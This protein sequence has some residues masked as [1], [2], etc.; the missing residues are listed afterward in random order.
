[1]QSV[2]CSQSI[3][4]TAEPLTAAAG[5]YKFTCRMLWH[6]TTAQD[7][8]AKLHAGFGYAV[9]ATGA[10]LRNAEAAGAELRYS[11]PVSALQLEKGRVIG[12]RFSA[13][14]V[15]TPLL[16][17]PPDHWPASAAST[18]TRRCDDRKWAV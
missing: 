18:W 17:P 16:H 6:H 12:K 3:G 11:E 5:E 15:L 7:G 9:E 4:S 1:M 13:A 2:T 14:A 10:F 8:R